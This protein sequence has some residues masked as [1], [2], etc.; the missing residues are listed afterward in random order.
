[1]LAKLKQERE[2]A[3]RMMDSLGQE[4]EAP[5]APAPDE[6]EP[7]TAPAPEPEKPEV[8]PANDSQ[9][10]AR[11]QDEIDR[12]RAQLDD[13]NNQ[14]HRSQALLFKSQRDTAREE[15]RELK[16]QLKE[17]PKPAPTPTPK[18]NEPDESDE[19]YKVLVEEY[20]ERAAKAMWR[21]AQSGK[22]STDEVN[23]LVEEKTKP[24][25]ETLE[26]VKKDQAI[27][28]EERF[29]SDL[30]V[31]VPDWRELNG[32]KGKP[33]DPKFTAF[34]SSP[35]P[36]QDYTYNDLLLHHYSKGNT[37]KVAQIFE[38]FKEMH[39]PAEVVPP[40][41]KPNPLESLVEPTKTNRG[42]ETPADNTKPI[43]TRKEIEEFDRQKRQGTLYGLTKEQIQTKSKLYQDAIFEGRVK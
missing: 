27:S 13:E 20:G 41:E 25:A 3:E 23:R 32:G 6:T 37:N 19:D 21:M 15:L 34:L 40:T 35:V 14:T 8:V 29:L 28:A 2:E 33:Q 4:Q 5:E 30:T 43:Y 39:K 24:V 12:L 16:E 26:T 11:L 38:T 22:V 1:M 17:T 18:A 42:T 36:L 31:K 9:E 10:I 7:Q